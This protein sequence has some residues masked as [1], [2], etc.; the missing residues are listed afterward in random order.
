MA[1]LTLTLVPVIVVFTKCEALELQAIDTLEQDMN[2]S[3]GEA[4]KQAP[5]YANKYLHNT[6]LELEKERYPPLDH[7]YL[8]G[9]WILIISWNNLREMN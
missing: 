2:L 4:V 7:V 6:H 5:A 3:Y 9:Q 8:Q 1:I